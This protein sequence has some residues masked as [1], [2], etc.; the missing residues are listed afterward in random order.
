MASIETQRMAKFYEQCLE[1]GYT[2]MQDDTQSLKAKVIATDLQLRYRD[3]AELYQKAEPCYQQVQKEK[4]EAAKRAKIQKEKEKQAEARRAVNG[5]LLLEF[6]DRKN[7]VR[8]YLR[9]DQ[10]VYSTINGGPKIEKKPELTLCKGASFGYQKDPHEIMRGDAFT[11]DYSLNGF[12]HIEV[13]YPERLIKTK[14]GYIRLQ[15]EKIDMPVVTVTVSSYIQDR[16]KRD[17]Q[18]KRLVSDDKISCMEDLDVFYS[19]SSSIRSTVSDPCIQMG[20]LSHQIDESRLPYNDCKAILE[21]LKRIV[22][23]KFPLTEEQIYES[24]LKMAESGPSS[25]LKRAMD[26][27]Q[28][29]SEYKDVPEQIARI[30]V[31]HEEILQAEKERAIL[32][33]EAQEQ[34]NRQIAK[35]AGLVLAAIAVIVFIIKTIG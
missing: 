33:K 16:F 21:L 32:E 29:I 10:S 6:S 11:G 20:M 15:L 18:F 5:E 24:A 9:P 3:I 14:K 19:I 12:H 8:V 22:Q 13:K 31:K 34:K 17:S 1:K 23:I 30:K 35:I 26:T 4:E 28:Q 27:L 2:D 25:Q 7:N